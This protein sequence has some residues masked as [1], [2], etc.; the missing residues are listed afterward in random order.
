MKPQTL[1]GL[2]VVVALA[3]ISGARANVI[4][5]GSFENPTI[6]YPWYENFGTGC[7][8]NCA[9]G[10]LPDWTVTTN[11]V[12][13]VSVVGG[14]PAPAYDGKQYLDLVGTGST[15]GISQTFATTVGVKYNL[16]FA[17]GNN[18]ESTSFAIA[19][20]EVTPGSSATLPAIFFANFS[21]ENN[22]GWEV[23]TASFVADSLFTT[24][25]FNELFG[26]NNGGVLLD[27]INVTATPLPST[28]LLLF[29][30]FVGL[31]FFAHRA[32]KKRTAA[33]VA[34]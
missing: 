21:T 8:G 29:S 25:S 12:D 5:N 7:L 3:T 22:I 16:S 15:G 28:W 18:P 4:L 2:A 24:L 31:G 32:T 20:V 11:N 34:A 27:A 17:Y 10:P 14:W 19:S 9:G 30:G 13:V 1:A 33:L 26:E 23:F 6:V